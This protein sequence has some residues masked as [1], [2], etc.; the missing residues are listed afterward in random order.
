MRI[1]ADENVEQMV[2]ERLR[3]DGYDVISVRL[4]SRGATDLPIPARAVNED[5][6]LLTADLDFGE[7]VFRDH[8]PAPN[9]GVVQYRLGDVLK[10]NEKARIIG[11]AFIQFLFSFAGNFCVIEEDNVRFRPLPHTSP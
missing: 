1:L 5:L 7:Y 3:S 2:I 4:E 8:L 9:A 10:E 6:L 11:E